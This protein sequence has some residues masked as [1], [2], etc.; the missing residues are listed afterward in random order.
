M[1]KRKFCALILFF[2][3]SHSLPPLLVA[4]VLQ[5][6]LLDAL[7][8]LVIEN[9]LCAHWFYLSEMKKEP[10]SKWAKT[11]YHVIWALAQVMLSHSS[12]AHASYPRC[13]FCSIS[14]NKFLQSMYRGILYTHSMFPF[15]Y[16]I[17]KECF[18]SSHSPYSGRSN[19]CEIFF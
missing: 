13:W 6:V 14:R 12:I 2:F 19:K 4:N 11:S 15:G 9:V 16:T 3:L 17:P 7:P 1:A 18:P 8:V 5:S 10:Y